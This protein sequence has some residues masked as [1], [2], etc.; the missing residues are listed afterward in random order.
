MNSLEFSFVFFILVPHSFGRCFDMSFSICWMGKD[1]VLERQ[2]ADVF[3]NG[4]SLKSIM[5]AGKVS[6]LKLFPVV[7]NKLAFRYG[8]STLRWTITVS[9]RTKTVKITG[10]HK[11]SEHPTN[12]TKDFLALLSPAEVFACGNGTT[13]FHQDENFFLAV[14]HTSRF[15]LKL[16]GRSPTMLLVSWVEM[17]PSILNTHSL[18]VYRRELGSY[19]VFTEE[20]TDRNH[21]RFSA[22][23]PCSHYLVCVELADSHAFTCL[24]AITDPDVPKDFEVTSWNSSSIS[25]SWDCPVNMKYSLFLLTVFYLNGTDHVWDEVS[26]WLTDDTFEFSLSDLQPCSRVKFGLQTVCQAGLETRYS[27][28]LLNDGNSGES[29]QMWLW[30][31]NNLHVFWG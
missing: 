24:S 31:P 19:N 12:T 17:D 4:T 10:R 5:K 2:N 6:S 15:P 21:H 30:I 26:L 18:T 20:T 7:E 11:P 8:G 27:K 13:F 16:E 29:C 28:I 3:F 25:L 1:D 9:P 23:E 14:G 22:L